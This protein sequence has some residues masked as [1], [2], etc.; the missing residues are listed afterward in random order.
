MKALPAMEEGFT[1]TK[2]LYTLKGKPIT[3]DRLQQGDQVI[4]LIYAEADDR[5]DKMVVINDML[6]AG[7]EIETVLTPEDAKTRNGDAGIYDFL[8]TLSYVDL[9]EARDDRF[10]AS[11]RSDGGGR[12]DRRWSRR[13][14]YIVRAVTEG[15]FAFPGAHI[16]DMYRPAIMA[17]TEGS[18]L[19]VTGSGAL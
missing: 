10:V 5:R 6:P 13:V 7:L 4:V 15:N 16:E 14:A 11:W 12:F 19:Q 8:G 17:T 9:Q 2:S 3:G 18:R 1:V